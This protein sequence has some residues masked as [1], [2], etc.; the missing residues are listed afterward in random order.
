MTEMMYDVDENGDLGGD[1][2][3]EEIIMIMSFSC[4]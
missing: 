4:S 2:Y 3:F 1:T